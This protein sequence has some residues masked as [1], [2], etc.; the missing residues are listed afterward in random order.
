M[1]DLVPTNPELL[2]YLGQALHIVTVVLQSQLGCLQ[3]EANAEAPSTFGHETEWLKIK[4][5]LAQTLLLHPFAI[6]LYLNVV[7][8]VPT[9]V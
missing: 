3:V 1:L 2:L 4:M 5:H 7:S 6:N 9:F 8:V